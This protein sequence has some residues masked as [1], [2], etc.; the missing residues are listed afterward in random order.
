MSPPRLSLAVLVFRSVTTRTSNVPDHLSDSLTNSLLSYL[1]LA[2]RIYVESYCASKTASFPLSCCKGETCNFVL[3]VRLAMSFDGAA[4]SNTRGY[5]E[6]VVKCE[7]WKMRSTEEL[8]LLNRRL[9]PNT[10]V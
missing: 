10:E 6:C 1:L 7:R 8:L 5:L 3:Q 4:A 9:G 2:R